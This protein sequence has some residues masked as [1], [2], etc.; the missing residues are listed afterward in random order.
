ME[1]VRLTDRRTANA[2]RGLCPDHLQVRCFLREPDDSRGGCESVRHIYSKN[3]IPYMW[4]LVWS[5]MRTHMRARLG[6]ETEQHF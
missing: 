3:K 1:N 6:I 5:P 4:R 2:T